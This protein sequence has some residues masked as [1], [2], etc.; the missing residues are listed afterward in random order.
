MKRYMPLSELKKLIEL[1]NKKWVENGGKLADY[2][3]PHCKATQQSTMPSSKE[4]CGPKGYWDTITKCPD[5][6]GFYSIKIWPDSKVE[7]IIYEMTE[8]INT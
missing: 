2:E 1:Y 8:V 6:G 3:C 7:T 4:L 5:C